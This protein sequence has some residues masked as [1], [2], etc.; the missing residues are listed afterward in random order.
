MFS[1]RQGISLI[2]ILSYLAATFIPCESIAKFGLVPAP[3]AV[4]M[5]ASEASSSPSHHGHAHH[6]KL[7]S[8]VGRGSEA[9]AEWKATCL[10]GCDETRSMI[11]GGAGRLGSVVPITHVARLLPAIETLGVFPSSTHRSEYHREIDPIPT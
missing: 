7:G 8:E 9:T 3:P 5:H 6:V 1:A 10:C 11:G 4:S 2:A